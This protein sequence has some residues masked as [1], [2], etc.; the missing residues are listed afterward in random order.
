MSRATDVYDNTVMESFFASCKL[1][2]VLERGFDARRQ[3]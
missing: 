2:C 1:E 3:A